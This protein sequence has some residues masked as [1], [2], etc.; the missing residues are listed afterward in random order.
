MFAQVENQ[1]IPILIFQCFSHQL[2]NRL[3]QLL[4]CLYATQTRVKALCGL[5]NRFKA[6]RPSQIVVVESGWLLFC[7]NDFLAQ[8]QV[9]GFCVVFLQLVNGVAV[10]IHQPYL[11]GQLGIAVYSGVS[12]AAQ[13]N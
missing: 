6:I 12:T 7:G 9:G 11:F 3:S 10:S 2:I 13:V 4:G 8:M 1:Q 5:I